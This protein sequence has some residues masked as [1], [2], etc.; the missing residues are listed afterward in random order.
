MCDIGPQWEAHTHILACPWLQPQFHPVTSDFCYLPR[1]QGPR[2]LVLALLPAQRLAHADGAHEAMDRAGYDC[3]FVAFFSSLLP[4]I[5]AGETEHRCGTD[6]AVFRL[7][8]ELRM[9]CLRLLW[10][11]R[12]A[13]Q[14]GHHRAVCMYRF[15]ATAWTLLHRVLFPASTYH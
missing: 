8:S 10:A 3:A 14:R 9:S 4:C 1:F 15:V 13:P 7:W 6:S 5:R 12:L 2:S 11:M